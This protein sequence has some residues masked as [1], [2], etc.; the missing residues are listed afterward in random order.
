MCVGK[1]CSIFFE[2]RR[3]G[4]YRFDDLL[5]VAGAKRA[6]T[7]QH[8]STAFAGD[9][10]YYFGDRNNPGAGAVTAGQRRGKARIHKLA[11]LCRRNV[12]RRT[13][14]FGPIE[15]DREPFARLLDRPVRSSLLIA[16]HDDKAGQCGCQTCT[17]SVARHQRSASVRR[18]IQRP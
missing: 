12:V 10:F 5:A 18:G 3:A 4:D 16:I 6:D 15:V 9:T 11:R 1:S 7:A 8:D 17:I 2:T 14:R 13:T